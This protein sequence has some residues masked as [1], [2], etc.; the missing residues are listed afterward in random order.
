MDPGE[1]K[2]LVSRV[3]PA[4]VSTP[5]TIGAAEGLGFEL[6]TTVSNEVCGYG[7]LALVRIHW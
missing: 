1:V 4:G 7:L 3:N 2:P 6:R 5:A